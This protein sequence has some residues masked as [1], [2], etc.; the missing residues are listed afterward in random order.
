M[1]MCLLLCD[2][3]R[4]TAMT[5]VDCRH[6]DDALVLTYNTASHVALV[7]LFLTI[8]LLTFEQ[9]LP[10]GNWLT[11]HSWQEYGMTLC[12]CGLYTL[13]RAVSTIQSA[14][15][16]QINPAESGWVARFTLWADNVAMSFQCLQQ[17]LGRHLSTPQLPHGMGHECISLR[18]TL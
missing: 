3:C 9:F 17:T 7:I 12:Y 2:L 11:P 4:W 14:W 1:A 16:M 5:S 6:T 18:M 13:P 8:L 15:W 10:S